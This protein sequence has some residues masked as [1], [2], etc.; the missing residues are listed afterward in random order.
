VTLAEYFKD[1]FYSSSATKRS[2]R[3]TKT[4]VHQIF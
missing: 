3:S 1:E 4:E 2:S